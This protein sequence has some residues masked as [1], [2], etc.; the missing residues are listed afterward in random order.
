MQQLDRYALYCV[1]V[2]VPACVLTPP[3]ETTT[4]CTLTGTV[5]GTTKFSCVTPTRPGGIPTK[6]TVA[7]TPPTVTVTGSFG[8]GSL[9]IAVPLSGLAPASG[10]DEGSPERESVVYGQ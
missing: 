3:T 2:R 1:T 6:A 8:R 5:V 7:A 10:N 4:G 9:D